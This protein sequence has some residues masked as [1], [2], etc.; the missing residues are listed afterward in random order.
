MNVPLPWH[1][2]IAAKIILSRLPL[3][4]GFW[5]KLSLFEHG[6]MEHPEYSL[7][8]AKKHL[9]KATFGRR[10]GDF[11]AVELGP[12]DTITSALA[13][14]ALGANKT[15]HVDVGAFAS[16][17]MSIY[18]TMADYLRTQKLVAPDL[19]EIESFEEMTREIPVQY[20]TE[21]HLSLANMEPESVDLV[22]SHAVLEHVGRAEFLETMRQTRRILRKDGV[23]TH[24]V[25]LK[26]HLAYGLN[27]LR[28]S[29]KTWESSFMSKSGF[30]TNRIRYSEMIA[31]FEKAGFE[32]CETTK[33]LFDALPTPKSKLWEPYRK[34][35]DEELMISDFDVVLRPR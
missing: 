12:G 22:W 6:Q 7:E 28:F 3:P 29:E 18:R 20:H 17:D 24:V 32:V 15:I 33:V 9:D 2:K 27:N 19:S 30:Y 14:L 16:T 35:P 5:K 25:D 34:L 10:N 23:A 11:T 26:D 1:A 21:G 8:V 31:L 4:Y 13:M